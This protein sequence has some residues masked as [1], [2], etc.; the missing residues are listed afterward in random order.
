MLEKID[1]LYLIILLQIV[2]HKMIYLIIIIKMTK[3]ITM[4][5]VCIINVYIIILGTNYQ[6]YKNAYS[7]IWFNIFI[8]T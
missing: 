7:S 5:Y 3:F 6:Y 4:N 8:N 2:N 1:D